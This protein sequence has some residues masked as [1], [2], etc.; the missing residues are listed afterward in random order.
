MKI[1]PNNAF[2]K[3]FY[4]FTTI[5]VLDF[6]MILIG[7]YLNPRQE[8]IGQEGLIIIPLLMFFWLWSWYIM[9][10]AFFMKKTLDSDSES[11]LPKKLYM[12]WI[13]K[14]HK[15]LQSDKYPLLTKIIAFLMIFLLCFISAYAFV[16][17]FYEVSNELYDFSSFTKEN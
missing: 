1:C 3:L 15:S 17:I 4:F 16:N 2:K 8:C 7:S 10:V 11:F 6:I 14:I 9:Y 13:G 12:W 5:F